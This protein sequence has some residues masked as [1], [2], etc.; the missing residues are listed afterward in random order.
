M[1]RD[2]GS[3][4]DSRKLIIVALAAAIALTVSCAGR[5]PQFST[6]DLYTEVDCAPI[7][8]PERRAACQHYDDG[9]VLY[10][11]ARYR[12]AYQKFVAAHDTIPHYSNHKAK[13]ECAL[14]LGRIEEALDL[15]VRY[16]E[17]ADLPDDRRVIAC[18]RVEEVIEISGVTRGTVPLRLDALGCISP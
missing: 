10:K 15:Y 13:A 14:Q 8:D 3:P 4:M 17:T 2:G 7:K 5:Q 11:Q 16:L 6:A 1:V 9:G 18:D 12:E